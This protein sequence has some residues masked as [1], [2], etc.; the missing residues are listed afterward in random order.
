VALVSRAWRIRWFNRRMAA[1]ARS[2]AKLQSSAMEL[3]VLK[4]IGENGLHEADQAHHQAE[5]E[6]FSRFEILLKQEIEHST[7]CQEI[8]HHHKDAGIGNEV[9][10]PERGVHLLFRHQA[11][12]P[13]LV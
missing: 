12:F 13:S 6:V 4:R 2:G 11:V 9:V 1:L 5:Q 3:R 7:S 8:G 10:E